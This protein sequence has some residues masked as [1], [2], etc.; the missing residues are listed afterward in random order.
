MDER[1]PQDNGRIIWQR[2]RFACCWRGRLERVHTV[3]SLLQRVLA[4]YLPCLS[5]WNIQRQP[6]SLW[7]QLVLQCT[8]S[9]CVFYEGLDQ[10]RL[11]VRVLKGLQLVHGW[12]VSHLYSAFLRSDRW[13][14]IFN[15]RSCGSGSL[16]CWNHPV[17]PFQ[18]SKRK[19]VGWA[20]PG[21]Q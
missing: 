2:K 6:F 14:C 20:K 5:C 13:H 7:M 18:N 4:S 3:H 8:I 21:Y 11:S 16:H 12:G 9:W 1:R 15:S 19:E 17:L 10:L